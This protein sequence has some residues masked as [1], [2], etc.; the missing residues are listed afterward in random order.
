MKKTFKLKNL[1]LS[2]AVAGAASVAMVPA[3]SQAGV[4]ANIGMVSNYVFRGIEQTESASASAG[5]DFESDS[6]FY[7]GTW[8][9]DVESGL[10]YDLY[11]GWAGEF[12][13]VSLGLGASGFYYTDTAFDS[14][15]E[16]VNASIGY[17][18][19]TIGYDKGTYKPSSGDVDYDHKYL[20]VAYED[21]SAT[22]GVNDGDIDTSDDAL[23]YLDLGYS[24]ELAAGFDGSIN[25]VATSS[26]DDATK[27]QSYLILGVSKSFDLM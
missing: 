20:S 25:F 3:A 5:L 8:A 11:G 18:M 16:E 9:A 22:Y 14:T 19:F 21:F 17:G 4:S 23:S 24:T 15:Y 1:A 7:I 10:E 6:G 12:E 27:D 2:L 13:G 26:E